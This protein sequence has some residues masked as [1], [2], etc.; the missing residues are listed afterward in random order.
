MGNP[1]AEAQELAARGVPEA[2]N[3][4]AT[5]EPSI[6]AIADWCANTYLTPSERRADT[7]AHT[8]TYLK[9]AMLTVANH[10]S[11][12]AQRLTR[13]I[14]LQASELE[15]IDAMMSLVENRIAYQRAALAHSAQTTLTANR[16]FAARTSG[17]LEMAPPRGGLEVTP[18][19]ATGMLDLSVLDDIGTLPPAE[20]ALFSSSDAE[21]PPPPPHDGASQLGTAS[22]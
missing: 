5:A 12:A 21:A 3:E 7:V 6:R 8:Q 14:E 4:L 15:S 20:P 22:L 18:R 17:S 9:D 10:A 13:Q 16:S 1:A 11:A 19:T 2:L